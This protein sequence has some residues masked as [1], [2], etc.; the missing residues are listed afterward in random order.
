M[1]NLFESKDEK[2]AKKQS[3]IDDK[4][5]KI[6]GLDSK[7]R[8]LRYRKEAAEER[9]SKTQHDFKLEKESLEHLIALKEERMEIDIERQLTERDKVHATKMADEQ[10]KYRDKVEKNLESERDNM[11]EMFERILERLPDV[12]AHF[13]VPKNES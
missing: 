5:I 8:E 4:Q 12:T 1:W 10:K 6:D 3:E 2:L 11:K 13:G 7:I 9:L